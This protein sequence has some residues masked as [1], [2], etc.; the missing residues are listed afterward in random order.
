ME[1]DETFTVTLSSATGATLG[2]AVSTVT[3]TNDDVPVVS[4]S[5]V[6]VSVVEGSSGTTAVTLTVGLSQA[7]LGT[8]TVGYATANGSASAGLDYTATSGTVTFSAGQTSQDIIVTVLG[9]ATVEADETFTVTLS[10]PSG[11]SLGATT[12]TVTIT[13]DDVPVVSISPV[14]VSVVEG[15]SGT[16]A[17]TLTVGLSQAPVG[18]VTVGYA[19]SLIHI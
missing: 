15:S 7:A 14:S 11:A 13:N 19:L 10:A 6:S 5:P 1:A 18:T 8:V 12:S 17:V 9:D 3:I 2:A 4:I 16:A